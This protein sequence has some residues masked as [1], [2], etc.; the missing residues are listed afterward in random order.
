[1]KK[2]LIANRGEI[3]VRIIRSCRE[4][5][6]RTVAIFSDTD[7]TSLHVQMADEAYRIGPPP[8]NKSYLQI[9]RILDIAEQS[10]ADAIHP[11]Y[12]FLSENFG[13]AEAVQKKGL[14]WIGPPPEAMSLLGDK[15]IARQIAEKAVVP[16]IPGSGSPVKNLDAAKKVASDIGF[17]ILVKAVG[18]GGGKGMR[19]VMNMNELKSAFKRARS[20]AAAAFDDDRLFIEKYFPSPHHIEIQIVADKFGNVVT[21]PER[22][23]SIQRRYQKIIEETPSPIIKRTLWKKMASAAQKICLNTGYQGVGT[24]EFLVDESKNFYFLEINTRLQVEHPITEEI[25]GV[26]L[27]REQLS[28]T[29]GSKLSFLQEDIN[30]TGHSIECRIYAEDGFQAFIPSVGTINELIL[31]EGPGIRFDHALQAGQEITPYYDPLLGK[32]IV[33]DESRE[34]TLLRMI[35]ALR[36]CKIGGIATTIP[37]CIAVLEHLQFQKGNYTTD[38]VANEMD[39]LRDTT[40][41]QHYLLIA[42]AI[43]AWHSRHYSTT[44]TPEKE[45]STKTPWK[46]IGRLENLR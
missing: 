2:I 43:A 15:V 31:P 22:E 30:I 17:P 8:A 28:I 19:I 5:G 27:V 14:I 24:V 42:A 39:K 11:G 7:R 37:F 18:G 25:T 16:V 34:K 38:F 20:E 44:I 3:A 9:N 45:I 35:R 10:C 36:E 33:Y 13:F 4:A 21:F 32:L 6:L 23:C 40:A 41:D 46:Q 12:G 1:M 26:D 29:A